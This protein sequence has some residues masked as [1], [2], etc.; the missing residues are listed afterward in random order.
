[1][2]RKIS[3]NVDGGP[4][5]GSFVCRPGSE[6]PHQRERNFFFSSPPHTFLLEGVVRRPV[7]ED[8]HRRQR[9]FTSNCV[10]CVKCIKYFSCIPPTLK[11]QYVSLSSVSSKIY[12]CVRPPPHI[13]I[14]TSS[15][16]PQLKLRVIHI[17]F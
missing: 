12:R 7:I 14:V 2:C 16:P 11:C 17:N 4:S 1:M 6:D 5:G 3:A 8:P 13:L 15:T 10:K 9:N